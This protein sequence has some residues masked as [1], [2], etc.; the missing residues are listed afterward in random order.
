MIQASSCSWLTSDSRPVLSRQGRML[1]LVTI[2]VSYIYTQPYTDDGVLLNE[3]V[4]PC[5]GREGHFLSDSI[6]GT[7]VPLPSPL[8]PLLWGHFALHQKGRREAG[9]TAQLETGWLHR[10]VLSCFVL[11]GLLWGCFGTHEVLRPQGPF[12]TRFPL[13]M[14]RYP[15]FK[16]GNCKFLPGEQQLLWITHSL[17]KPVW[18]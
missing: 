3:L 1:C 18:D 16:C 7:R 15:P 6:P 4:C 8:A 14:T 5:Q 11:V 10:V 12:Q 2:T 9:E 13:G 17:N